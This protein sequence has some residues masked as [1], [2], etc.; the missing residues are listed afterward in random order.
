MISARY[1]DGVFQAT[2]IIKEFLVN[3][4][5]AVFRR[6]KRPHLRTVYTSPWKPSNPLQMDIDMSKQQTKRAHSKGVDYVTRCKYLNDGF[7][8]HRWNPEQACDSKLRRSA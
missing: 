5:S 2:E 4:M 6:A 7:R 3:F 1:R 8:F